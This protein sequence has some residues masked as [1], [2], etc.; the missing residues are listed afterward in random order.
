MKRSPRGLLWA[1]TDLCVPTQLWTDPG[2]S[3]LESTYNQGT[4][5]GPAQVPHIKVTA[6]GSSLNVKALLGWFQ[7]PTSHIHSQ[8]QTGC[9][10]AQ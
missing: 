10:A 2:L 4:R 1:G 3:R 5:P 8:L 9:R 6:L 7:A